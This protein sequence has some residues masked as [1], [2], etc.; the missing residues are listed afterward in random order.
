M[1][2]LTMSISVD[3]IISSIVDSFERQQEDILV[4][5]FDEVKHKTPV[6]TGKAR[7]GWELDRNKIVNN[8]DYIGQLET[9]TLHTRPIGMV[10]TTLNDIDTIVSSVCRRTV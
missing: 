8:V 5:I 9:G 6:S 1:K 10:A 3:S 7:A 4:T 2:G